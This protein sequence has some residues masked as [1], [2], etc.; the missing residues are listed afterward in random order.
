MSYTGYSFK[1]LQTAIDGALKAPNI[2][3][4]IGKSANGLIRIAD[5]YMK[6]DGEE[7]WLAKVTDAAGNPLFT[8]EEQHKIESALSGPAPTA[9]PCLGCPRQY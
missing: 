8:P 4:R 1:N 3:D 6:A 5:G 2:Q 7:G 9:L